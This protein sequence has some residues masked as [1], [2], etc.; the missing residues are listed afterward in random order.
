MKISVAIPTF[1]SS[2][3]LTPNLNNLI[4]TNLISE[5]VIRDDCSNHKDIELADK[6]IKSFKKKTKIDIRYFQNKENLGAFEN[7]L[8]VIKD[9]RQEYV[10]QLDSDNIPMNNLNN[11]LNRFI[12]Y[13][14]DPSL[15]YLP[16]KIFQF[17]K[18]QNI[19]RY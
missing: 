10:Y 9:C 8:K 19:C 14:K 4:K 2:K 1:N 12:K 11:Y 15:L 3:Y 5:I 13:S 7:K 16:S 17:R 18:Y 6:I